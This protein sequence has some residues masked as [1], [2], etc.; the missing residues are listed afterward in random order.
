MKDNFVKVIDAKG[1]MLLDAKLLVWILF[2]MEWGT[3]EF[4]LDV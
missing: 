4:C 1:W 3:L 2:Y